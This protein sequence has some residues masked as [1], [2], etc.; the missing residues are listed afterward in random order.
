MAQSRPT[1]YDVD[2]VFDSPEAIYEQLWL[3]VTEQDDI[4]SS[5]GTGDRTATVNVIEDDD[6]LFSEATLVSGGHV[7]VTED[8]DTLSSQALLLIQGTLS[9]LED[10]DT[11]FSTSSLPVLATLGVTEDNDTFKSHMIKLPWSGDGNTITSRP[12]TEDTGSNGL[13]FGI[14]SG[15]TNRPYEEN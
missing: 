15:A 11:F 1:R 6:T 7:T 12:Y 14:T 2:A 4:L 9:S 8:D 3:V 10:D 13:P 5:E